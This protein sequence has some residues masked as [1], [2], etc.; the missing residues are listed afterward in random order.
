MKYI[1]FFFAIW[2]LFLLSAPLLYAETDY[3]YLIRV[4]LDQRKLFL[5]PADNETQVLTS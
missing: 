3:Q 2:F 1:R 5:H 4:S